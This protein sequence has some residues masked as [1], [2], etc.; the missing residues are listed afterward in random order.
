MQYFIKTVS[1]S[2]GRNVFFNFGKDKHNKYK[3]TETYY[4][5]SGISI[6]VYKNNEF[7]KYRKHYVALL[8]DYDCA[9]AIH[10]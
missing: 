3:D 7:R 8:N 4:G 5:K 6:T 10:I 2:K 9:L 1:D